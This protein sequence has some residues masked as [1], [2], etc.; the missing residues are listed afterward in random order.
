MSFPNHINTCST[1]SQ[2]FE[3]CRTSVVTVTVKC[4]LDV[5]LVV[6][7]HGVVIHRKLYYLYVM[8]D[9]SCWFI[10]YSKCQIIVEIFSLQTS[11]S[12]VEHLVI[13]EEASRPF[14]ITSPTLSRLFTMW[15]QS[16]RSDLGPWI[17]IFHS[18]CLLEQLHCTILEP[19]IHPS[20]LELCNLLRKAG[21]NYALRKNKHQ[22]VF[23]CS[24]TMYCR[25]L[26]SLDLH[27]CAK[28]SP[29]HHSP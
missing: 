29:K 13:S 28:A 20:P 21:L 18:S 12:L 15:F 10:T 23:L 9:L 22:V 3:H 16:S 1:Y 11:V 27:N 19:K 8:G 5:A 24:W 4:I 7:S 6:T 14:N 26:P 25:I 2:C 17:G